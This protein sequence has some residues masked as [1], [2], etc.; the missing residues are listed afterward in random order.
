MVFAGDAE[1]GLHDKFRAHAHFRYLTGIGNEAGAAVLFDPTAEDPAR[2]CVLFLRP[3]NPDTEKW[4]GY[5]AEINEALKA[6]T[7]FGVVHRTGVLPRLLTDAVRRSKRAACLQP[8][9]V[10]P[11]AVSADLHA[12]Q[13]VAARVPGVKIEDMTGVLNGMRAVKSRAELALMRRAA[14]ITA[15]GYEAAMGV[16]GP[17]VNERRVQQA[18]E[19]AYFAGGAED[20]A[21]AS[22]VGSGLNSTVLHYNANDA[23]CEEGDLLVIDSGAQFKGYACDVTRT[24][25]VSGRFTKEQRG[26]Y[27]IVLRAQLAAIRACKPGVKM[28]RVDAEARD[29]IKAAGLGDYFIHG[30]GHQLG[31]EVHD[32]SPDGALKAGMVVT[33]EPGVYVPE[34]RTGIRIEDDVLVTEGGARVLTGEVPKSVDEV[35][36]AMARGRKRGA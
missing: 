13:Q 31:L 24:Y 18:I 1:A 27:E 17:G 12:I 36:R 3:R 29:V 4:D 34:I 26:L 32:A 10:Y 15:A 20:V 7:G 16:I 35:E 23:A 5:R 28:Y 21:Y 14:E 33:I 19:G 22:I 6:S 25:P 30:I 8:F 11:G 2:R 9:G